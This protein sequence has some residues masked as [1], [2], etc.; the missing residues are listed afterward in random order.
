MDVVIIYDQNVFSIIQCSFWLQVGAKVKCPDSFGISDVR[1]NTCQIWRTWFRDFKMRSYIHRILYTFVWLQALKEQVSSSSTW[2]VCGQWFFFRNLK[3]W[4]SMCCS[5]GRSENPESGVA[6]AGHG[7]VPGNQVTHTSRCPNCIVGWLQV[8]TWFFGSATPWFSNDVDPWSILYILVVGFSEF[9][10]WRRPCPS[11]SKTAKC[12][13]EKL[14]DC[15]P[16]DRV[17]DIVVLS[18]YGLFSWG[19]LTE[20]GEFLIQPSMILQFKFKPSYNQDIKMRS[21]FLRKEINFLQVLDLTFTLLC[22]QQFWLPFSDELHASFDPGN[23]G[24]TDEGV[25]CIEM[26]WECRH[27]HHFFG[28]TWS[29]NVIGLVA[30]IEVMVA[31]ALENLENCENCQTRFRLKACGFHQHRC[32]RTHEPDLAV[33]RGIS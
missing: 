11:A 9:H 3:C 17:S 25:S 29:L 1:Q 18:C 6:E 30:T 26:I 13:K 21:M 31:S 22:S 16:K 32:H 20:D 2:G 14:V 8:S 4:G 5:D 7:E 28:K 27:V 15:L 33:G 12:W 24:N 19:S 23:H 10:F